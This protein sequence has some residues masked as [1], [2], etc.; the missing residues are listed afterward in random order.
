M[1]FYN[2]LSSSNNTK[3]YPCEWTISYDNMKNP[4]LTDPLFIDIQ[5]RVASNFS[6]MTNHTI[7]NN[8]EHKYS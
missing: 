1:L 4:N 7:V 6:L 2:V 8:L 3:F 5:V